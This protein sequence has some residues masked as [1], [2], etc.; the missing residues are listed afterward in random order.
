MLKSYLKLKLLLLGI[1]KKTGKA[2]A[3]SA[4]EYATEFHE[5]KADLLLVITPTKASDLGCETGDVR[6]WMWEVLNNRIL[7]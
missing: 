1:L 2:V 5:G 6:C 7:K 4:S 3:Q